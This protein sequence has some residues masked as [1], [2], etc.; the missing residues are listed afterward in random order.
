LVSLVAALLTLEIEVVVARA[1]LWRLIV[2]LLAIVLF[3]E[4]FMRSPSID[5]CAVHTEMLI[6]GVLRPLGQRLDALEE[7][8]CN[9]LIKQEVGIRCSSVV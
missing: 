6:A 7:Q 4:G 3:D 2:R 8:A 5:Q 9:I 1:T